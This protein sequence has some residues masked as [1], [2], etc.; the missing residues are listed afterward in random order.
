MRGPLDAVATAMWVWSLDT[1]KDLDRL[2]VKS[3]NLAKLASVTDDEPSI[4]I[5][6]SAFAEQTVTPECIISRV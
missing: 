6:I 5:P 4:K 3:N 1:E 2:F